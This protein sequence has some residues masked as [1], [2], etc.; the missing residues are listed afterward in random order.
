MSR[1]MRDRSYGMCDK[2]MCDQYWVKKLLWQRYIMQYRKV[3]SMEVWGRVQRCIRMKYEQGQLLHPFMRGEK[4]RPI[5]EYVKLPKQVEKKLQ[6]TKLQKL[7]LS[8]RQQ[9]LSNNIPSQNTKLNPSSCLKPPVTSPPP[10]SPPTPHIPL[11]VMSACQAACDRPNH[12]AEKNVKEKV[13]IN[14]SNALD[15]L[16][17]YFPSNADLNDNTIDP[18]TYYN[19]KIRMTACQIKAQIPQTSTKQSPYEKQRL[20]KEESM[21]LKKYALNR[22]RFYN[23]R[24]SSKVSIKPAQSEEDHIALLPCSNCSRTTV[25]YPCSCRNMVYCGRVCQVSLTKV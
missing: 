18:K 1:D 3:P 13:K 22:K 25:V 17:M 24:K 15:L 5:Q 20:T 7:K 19:D 4:E 9:Y 2:Y 23:R 21:E 14:K 11:S 10:Q 6:D 8:M 12:L 16:Y